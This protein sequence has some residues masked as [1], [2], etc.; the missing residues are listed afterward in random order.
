MK[1]SG[2]VSGEGY[3]TYSREYF[4]LPARLLDVLSAVMTYTFLEPRLRVTASALRWQA[5]VTNT[6]FICAVLYY[7]LGILL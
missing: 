2:A 7:K 3:V 1:S 4:E 5:S 6:R